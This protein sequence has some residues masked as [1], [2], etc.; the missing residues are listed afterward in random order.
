MTTSERGRAGQL[1]VLRPT[2]NGSTPTLPGNV[3]IGSYD[4][5]RA[6]GGE[7]T[8]QSNLSLQDGSIPTWA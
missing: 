8:W 3:L 6:A 4:V 5:A 1:A 7:L 2:S